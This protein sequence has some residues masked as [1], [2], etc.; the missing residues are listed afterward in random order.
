MTLLKK[1]WSWPSGGCRH[2][3]GGQWVMDLKSFAVITKANEHQIQSNF[4]ILKYQDEEMI[5]KKLS[6]IAPEDVGLLPVGP[7]KNVASN[8]GFEEKERLKEKI[9]GQIINGIHS[10]ALLR[11]IFFELNMRRCYRK[12][13]GR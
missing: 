1:D 4:E 11:I 8:W 10:E 7:R 3:L 12:S 13:S 9:R 2:Q 6:A 5:G